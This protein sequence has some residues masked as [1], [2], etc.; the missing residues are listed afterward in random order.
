M[1]ISIFALALALVATPGLAAS[2]PDAAETQPAVVEGG[3]EQ[4]DIEVVG[5]REAEE[6]ARAEAE[7][8]AGAQKKVCRNI[9]VVGT[10]FKERVC[11][12]KSEWDGTENSMKD[13]AAEMKRS[14]ADLVAKTGNA[15]HPVASPF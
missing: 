2:Q 6:A 7:A 10:R 13:V 14:G 15:D 12:T 5:Q 1:K 3:T 4:V 11:Q 9:A 8:Q